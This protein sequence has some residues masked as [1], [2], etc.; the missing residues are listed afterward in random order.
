MIGTEHLT[1]ERMGATAVVTMNRPEAKNALSG[2][3]ARGHGRRLGGDRHQR[4]HPLRHPHRCRG[5]LLRRHGPQV[6]VRARATRRSPRRMA[7]DPDLHW[8][9]LLRHYSLKKPL[10]AAV[11]GWAV[12]G[13][14]EILQAT[15]IRV[16]GEGAKFGVFEAR[17]G[18]FPLGGSTVRLRRQI[19][20]TVAMDLLLTARE[21]SAAEAKEIGLIGRVVPDGK[22]LE[23]ALEIAEVIAANGPL[24]RRGHQGIGEGHRG[25]PRGG[26]PQDGARVR[27]ADLRHRG[28]QGGPAGLRRE[29]AAQLQAPVSELYPSD[30]P[31]LGPAPTPRRRAAPAHH[32]G[33]ERRARGRGGAR[34]GRGRRGRDRTAGRGSRPSAPPAPA[35]PRRRRPGVLPDEPHHRDGEPPRPAGHGRGRR[36]GRRAVPRELRARGLVRLPLRGPAHLRA[37][38]GHRRDLRRAAGRGQHRG[39]VPGH[40]RHADRA[41]SQAHAVADRPA[42]RGPHAWVASGRKIHTW[43]GMYHGERAHGRGRGDLHRAPARRGSWPSP[44]ATWTSTTRRPRVRPD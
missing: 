19:P 18:L 13:G 7:E 21:V 36:R 37:W 8:K 6:D 39:R 25:Y 20:F 27:L 14:T 24:G 43:G 33:G 22:A 12:A 31:E 11:E 4:R 9:A 42:H 34:S 15:D 2:P 3:D 35:R 38:R 16:A 23:A 28:R 26:G 10:I 1:F 30:S 29:A 40:D 41:L 32:H 17:R 44:R 5:H